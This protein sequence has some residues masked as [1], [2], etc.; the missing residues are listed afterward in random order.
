MGMVGNLFGN[1]LGNNGTG[2]TSHPSPE[3]SGIL[4]LNKGDVLDLTKRNPSLTRVRAAVG[5]DFV[6]IGTKYDLDLCAFMMS[7]TTVRTIVYYGNQNSSGIYLDGDNLTGLGT[8]DKENIRVQLDKI[9]TEVDRIVFAVV[10]YSAKERNQKFSNVKNAYMRVIDETNKS[11]ICRYIMTDDGGNNTAATLASL[12]RN[13]DDWQFCAI[14]KY[15]I[16][17]IS[18]LSK[19][20]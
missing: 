9:P 17:S 15:S 14:G 10:I 13:G 2:D 20:V 4:N 18:S 19:K 11:E 5:W 8:G 1:L 16:D 6:K 12:V 7:G 3:S